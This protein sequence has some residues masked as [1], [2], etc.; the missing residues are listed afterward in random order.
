MPSSARSRQLAAILLL[1]AAP[2]LNGALGPH[3]NFDS[4]I[5]A[6]HNRERSAADLS[7]LRWDADLAQSAAAWA[8]HLARTGRFEHSP[9]HPGEEIQGENLWAGTPGH[10]QPESM[11]GLWISEKRHF[12]PGV[13][14][15]NSRSGQVQDVS[16]YTQVMWRRSRAV[17]CALSRG[18]SEDVLVCR[19][20]QA[21]NIVGEVPF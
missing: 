21:G 4:R 7:L 8:R 11:V 2:A 1:L 16:H 10:Y 5:L 15:Y 3:T 9:D 13:F 20:K 14:P 19:Y 18:R 12:R 17:G 6:A